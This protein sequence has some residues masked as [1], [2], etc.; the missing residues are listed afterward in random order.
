MAHVVFDR[1]GGGRSL[2]LLPGAGADARLW[3]PLVTLLEP[4]FELHVA[5]IAGFAGRPREPGRLWPRVE[6]EVAEYVSALESAPVVVAHSWAGLLGWSL[7]ARGA[8]IAAG[9]VID[10]LP[11]LG[12][13]IARDPETLRR[14]VAERV[15]KLRAVAPAELAGHLE[16]SVARM[17]RSVEQARRILAVAAR[18]DPTTL[19]EAMEAAWLADLR[20]ALI[21]GTT[22][23]TLVLPGDEHLPPAAKASKHTVAYGQVAALPHHRVVEV[24]QSSH[25]V[26]LDQPNALAAIVHDVAQGV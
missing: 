14:A 1:R 10:S 6:E 24:P 2:L 11:A 4:W 22:P 7:S 16:A 23:V 5:E 20:P 18:S 25:Y 3:D 15:A 21:E 12:A 19:A 13:L 9:V 17:T 8:P 26:M